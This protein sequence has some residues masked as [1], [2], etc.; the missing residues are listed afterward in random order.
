MQ[1]EDP[2]KSNSD[3]FL[4]YHF[5]TD[6]SSNEHIV[7]FAVM[8]YGDEKEFVFEDYDSLDRFCKFLLSSEHKVSRPLLI[9]LRVWFRFH[10]TVG[11]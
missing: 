1:K 8:Q 10:S 11:Y 7:N 5:E 9:I 3:K 2:K 6:Q 4:F